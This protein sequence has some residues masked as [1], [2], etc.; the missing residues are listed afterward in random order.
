MECQVDAAAPSTHLTNS[1]AITLQVQVAIGNNLASCIVANPADERRLACRVPAGKPFSTVGTV[2]RLDVSCMANLIACHQ[3][4]CHESPDALIQLQPASVH[5]THRPAQ[6]VFSG[7]PM[8]I[9]QHP[10]LDRPAS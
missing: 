1:T 6:Q 4:T 2:L 10:V 8:L 7:R 5:R 9:E 3:A